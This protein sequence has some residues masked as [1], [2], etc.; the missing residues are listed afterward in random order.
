MGKY[1]EVRWGVADVKAK[2]ESTGVGVSGAWTTKPQ[3]FY[4]R[5]KLSLVWSLDDITPKPQLG[6]FG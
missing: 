2:V 4:P 1:D 3:A 5:E 6:L